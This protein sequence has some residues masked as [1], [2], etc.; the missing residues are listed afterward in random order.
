ML[1]LVAFH[2]VFYQATVVV[3]CILDRLSLL[4]VVLCNLANC[5]SPMPTIKYTGELK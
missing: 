2:V 4:V 1:A 3:N 5:I